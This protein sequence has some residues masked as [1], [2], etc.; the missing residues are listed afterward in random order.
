MSEGGTVDSRGIGWSVS[1]KES[2]TGS[3]LRIRVHSLFTGKKPEQGTCIQRD[4]VHMVFVGIFI[5]QN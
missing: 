2:V 5:F 3:R 1:R 4:C